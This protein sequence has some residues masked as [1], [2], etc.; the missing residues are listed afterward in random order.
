[1]LMGNVDAATSEMPHFKEGIAP[2]SRRVK[3]LGVERSII[4]DF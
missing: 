4:R 1:M 2:G 3:G